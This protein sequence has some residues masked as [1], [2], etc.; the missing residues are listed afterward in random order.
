MATD[1]GTADALGLTL[2]RLLQPDGINARHRTQLYVTPQLVQTVKTFNFSASGD[3]SFAGSSRGI[4]IFAVPWR[5]H[6]S[7]AKEATEEDCYQ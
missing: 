6:E 1:G 3:K 5:S 4:T 7:M 2:R